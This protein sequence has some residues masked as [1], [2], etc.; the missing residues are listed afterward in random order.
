MIIIRLIINK[1]KRRQNYFY[2]N[3]N[4]K[5]LA[6]GD[7]NVLKYNEQLFMLVLI[8]WKKFSKEKME[9]MACLGFLDSCFLM[10]FQKTTPSTVIFLVS[11]VTLYLRLASPQIRVMCSWCDCLE[12]PNGLICFDVV[13][14]MV[15]YGTCGSRVGT[16]PVGSYCTHLFSLQKENCI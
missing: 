8:H 13:P 15:S 12:V 16:R 11:S 3:V 7:D 2:W 1:S 4:A 14:F 9:L 10:S 5:R 6:A